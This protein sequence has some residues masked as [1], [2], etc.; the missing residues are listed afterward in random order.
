MDFSKI[1]FVIFVRLTSRISNVSE[2]SRPSESEYIFEYLM[3]INFHFEQ[4]ANVQLKQ[5]TQQTYPKSNI[6]LFGTEEWKLLW[7]VKYDEWG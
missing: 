1:S 6:R 5:K 4:C 2:M 7:V 3:E